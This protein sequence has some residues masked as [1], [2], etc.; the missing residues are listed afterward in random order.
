MGYHN[1]KNTETE[2]PELDILLSHQ[3]RSPLSAIRWFTEMLLNH[4]AGS[5]THEQ[6][7]YLSEIQRAHENTSQ[8][9]DEM[10]NSISNPSG[11]LGSPDAA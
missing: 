2:V 6:R 10:L 7:L 9:I 11:R 8:L 1:I 3:L 4:D 5:L